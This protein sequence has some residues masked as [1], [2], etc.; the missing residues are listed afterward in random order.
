MLKYIGHFT[1]LTL[2]AEVTVN[3]SSKIVSFFFLPLSNL[4]KLPAYADASKYKTDNINIVS[5]GLELPGLITMPIQTSASKVALVIFVGGSGP[6]DMDET[7]E[8]EKPFKD[9][10]IG[11]ALNGISSLR[12]NKRTYQYHNL[13]SNITIK[14]EYLDDIAAAIKAAKVIPGVNPEEIFIAGHSLGGMLSPL[15]LKEN[16]SL[17]GAI[18]LEA[19]ARP[20]EDLMYEQ[21]VHFSKIHYNQITDD[22]LK[23]LY[24]TTQKIKNI[25]VKDTSETY[26][27]VKGSY[28][29]LL[30]TYEPLK[31]ATTIKTQ[32]MLIIQGGYDYQVTKTDF[33]L[34]SGA[35]S[36]NKDV[37]FKFYPTLNHA[38]DE[39]KGALSPAEYSV[40][41]NTPVYLANDIS[42]WIKLYGK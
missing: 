30:N 21:L 1:G 34:W 5:N 19:N 32:K 40:P 39:G 36:K 29:L 2:E 22:G 27:N 8:A 18:L 20:V 16:P 13:P 24:A 31:V 23:A 38:L 7:M 26:L 28:W 3:D 41:V 4:Y 25:T 9:L 42:A 14:E 12:Y 6:N 11:L 35:L 17:A 10:S 15:I 33:N 37:S